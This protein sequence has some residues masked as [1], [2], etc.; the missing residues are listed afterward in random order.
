M[1]SLRSVVA[2]GSTVIVMGCQTLA[3]AGAAGRPT[4]SA[5]SPSAVS[6]NVAQTAMP[7]ET[8]AS[9]KNSSTAAMTRSNRKLILIGAVVAAIVIV[10]IV[11]AGGDG[12]SGRGY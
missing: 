10:A 7:A 5:Y 8:T 12:D 6:N 1:R 4:S 3:G 2:L 9:A 11:V